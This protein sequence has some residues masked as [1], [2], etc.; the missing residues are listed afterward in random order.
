MKPH[1][2]IPWKYD[3]VI[4]LTKEAQLYVFILSEFALFFILKAF[5]RDNFYAIKITCFECTIQ[6]F[7]VTV[8]SCAAIITIH[9]W[10]ISNALRKCC[11]YA[12]LVILYPHD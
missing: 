8:Q 1:S 5:S 4:H 2:D 12:F 9:F 3:I 6:W 7:L 10:N 11:L